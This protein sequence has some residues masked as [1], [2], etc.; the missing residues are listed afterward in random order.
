MAERKKQRRTGKAFGE[1]GLEKKRGARMSILQFKTANCKDCYKCIRHCAI[2]AIEVRDHQAQIIER[3]C[4]LCG[5]CTLVCP[6]N[7]KEVRNDVH[8]VKEW[9]RAGKTVV[10]NVAPSFAAHYAVNDFASFAA[11]LYSL[12]FAQAKETA[13][14]AFWVKSQ[15]E[16]LLA[17]QEYPVLISS[18]CPTVNQ[19]IEK[20]YPKAIPYLAPVM[21]PMQAQAQA[22]KQTQPDA[23]VVFIGPCIAKKAECEQQPG[24]TDCVLTFEE[25]NGWMEEE[26][27]TLPPLAESPAEPRYRSRFFPMGGGIIAS[28]DA[29][30]DTQYIC[31]DELENC[32]DALQEI[33]DGKL[34]HCFV[35]MSACKGSCINGPAT[36]HRSPHTIAAT[37]KV[38]TFASQPGGMVDFDTPNDT[39]LAQSFRDRQVVFPVPN[40]AEIAAILH[41]MGKNT[42]EDELNCGACG[43]ATCREKAIAIY[44]GKADVS[45]CLP[46]MKKKAE[47]MADQIIQ[48]TPNGIIVVDVQMKIQQINQAA[49]RLFQIQNPSDAIG[50]PISQIMDEFDFVQA[51]SNQQS[52]FDQ[53]AYLAEYRKNL[54]QSFIYDAED[55]LV[56]C[57]MKDITEEEANRENLRKTKNE[58]VEITDKIIAKQ[59][60]IV[61]EIAS[62]LGE[63]AA[64]TKIALTKLQHTVVME[65]QEER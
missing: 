14:G 44:Y 8:L 29:Q 19:L 41:K 13:E 50:M 28:M 51:F 30:P 61:Q 22:I 62:L 63:T 40:Q 38:R 43:Y 24:L 60:R 58:A 48:A 59:M 15:Y 54:E 34:T 56:F 9:I 12:G 32:M 5:R 25:L 6:Q 17:K 10:A 16:E 47:S 35:E 26:H 1:K 36:G 31:I 64:E 7:A 18:C 49:C 45:M 53:K 4:V 23:L 11:M 55:N 52:T 20:H 2:K 27:V 37:A 33:I 3:D 39:P 42:A 46:Y 65:E 57:I 21:T